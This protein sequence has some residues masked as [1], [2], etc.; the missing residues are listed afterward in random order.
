MTQA[1]IQ[2]EVLFQDWLERAMETPGLSREAWAKRA[3][4]GGESVS[5][6]LDSKFVEFDLLCSRFLNPTELIRPGRA[7]GDYRLVRHLGAGAYGGVWEAVQMTLNRPVALKFLHPVVALSPMASER[8]RQEAE[9]AAQVN[10][11]N[12]VTVFGIGHEKGVDF[13]VTELVETVGMIGQIHRAE[14]L[15]PSQELSN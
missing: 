7:L 3:A 4:E 8:L 5:V 6:E 9:A 11:V 10:H 1:E 14:F 15:F 13:L 12:V 2:A